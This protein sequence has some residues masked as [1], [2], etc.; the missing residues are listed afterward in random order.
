VLSSYG[1]DSSVNF[2]INKSSD[3]STATDIGV[4]STNS[5]IDIDIDIDKN[6][7]DSSGAMNVG[8]DRPIEN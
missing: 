8:D 6:N 5:S 2:D 1:C 4:S 7:V 3:I